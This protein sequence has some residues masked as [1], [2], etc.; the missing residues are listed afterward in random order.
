MLA[1]LAGFGAF[2]GVNMVL[3]AVHGFA[4]GASQFMNMLLRYSV[5]AMPIRV[6]G[7]VA[8]A[9]VGWAVFD[10]LK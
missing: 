8:A 7:L 9:W 10:S 2:V 6:A 5:L 3:G 4:C 1:A